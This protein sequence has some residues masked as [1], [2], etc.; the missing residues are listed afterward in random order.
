MDYQ[1][2]WEFVSQSFEILPRKLKKVWE[3]SQTSGGTF[4]NLSDN[5][6]WV[7]S[8]NHS[9]EG[10]IQTQ[11]LKMAE[12]YFFKCP[13]KPHPHIKTQNSCRYTHFHKT[14]QVGYELAKSWN[15]NNHTVFRCI[16]ISIFC[17]PC[18]NNSGLICKYL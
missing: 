1:G 2:V 9:E 10:V 13:I 8:V 6:H 16:Q 3:F 17:E 11:S 12:K 4:L 18:T 5:L 14:A 7:V 15:H